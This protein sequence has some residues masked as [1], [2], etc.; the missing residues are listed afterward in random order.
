M[1]PLSLAAL[2]LAAC[3]P[4]LRPLPGPADPAPDPMELPIPANPAT[5]GVPAGEVARLL[6]SKRLMVPV[7]G[8]APERVADTFTARRGQRIHSALDIMAPRGTPVVSAGAGK[9]W[10]V[11]SN[12]LGGLTVYVL[13]ADERFVYYYAHLDRYAKG[14]AE[15]QALQPGDVIGYV[16]TTG[17][18]PPNTPH[19]HFQVLLY[20]GNGR[21]WDGDPLN[22]RPYLAREGRAR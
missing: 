11:R 18:A 6:A 14:L 17:N 12:T 3:S 21:W 7:A 5:A 15:G 2:L 13:D 8:V 19:L 22:P 4:G 16:G 10:K 20:K 9:V 1:V